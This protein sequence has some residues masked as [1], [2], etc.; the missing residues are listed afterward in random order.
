MEVVSFEWAAIQIGDAFAG[1]GGSV[2]DGVQF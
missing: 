1:V 2:G